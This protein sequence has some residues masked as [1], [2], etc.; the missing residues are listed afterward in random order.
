MPALPPPGR[1]DPRSARIFRRGRR[2][3]LLR[4]NQP[5]GGAPRQTHPRCA[6][7]K[8]SC[9][10]RR[11]PKL[12][13]QAPKCLPDSAKARP[14]A[15]GTR[16][17]RAAQSSFSGRSPGRR[18]RK[19]AETP[20]ISAPRPA[21]LGTPAPRP[22]SARDNPHKPHPKGSPAAFLQGFLQAPAAVFLSA[23]PTKTPVF[24]VDYNSFSCPPI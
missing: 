23:Y 20:K 14:P 11:S 22:G 7:A 5:W 18:S 1:A 6:P 17:A 8:P 19:K 4:I 10:R 2:P 21:C 12:R 24:F 3:S 15:P 9:I 13:S 16:A